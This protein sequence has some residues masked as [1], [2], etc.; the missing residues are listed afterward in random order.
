MSHVVNYNIFSHDNEGEKVIHQQDNYTYAHIT[1]SEANIRTTEDTEVSQLGQRN[2]LF[3][4]KKNGWMM[5][6][7]TGLFEKFS[8]HSQHVNCL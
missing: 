5:K 2:V 4:G 7:M 8:K 1:S 3:R 6:M